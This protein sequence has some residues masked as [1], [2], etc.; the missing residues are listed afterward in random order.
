M[1]KRTECSAT[2]LT[3]A[4]GAHDVEDVVGWTEELLALDGRAPVGQ[5]PV[6]DSEQSDSVAEAGVTAEENC[7]GARPVPHPPADVYFPGRQVVCQTSASH[8]R[9]VLEHLC[10]A[11]RFV[12]RKRFPEVPLEVE[13]DVIDPRS[14]RSNRNEF[15]SEFREELPPSF[16]PRLDDPRPHELLEVAYVQGRFKDEDALGQ[17]HSMQP[18]VL[19]T[20]QQPSDAPMFVETDADRVVKKHNERTDDEDDADRGTEENEADDDV[21]EGDQER[22]EERSI[23][24]MDQSQHRSAPQQGSIG[25][26]GGRRLIQGGGGEGMR[27]RAG[28]GGVQRMDLLSSEFDDRLSGG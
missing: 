26:G 3:G 5:L 23:Q 16:V 24:L 11:P 1:E 25:C 20:A 8:L 7:R 18:E 17:G 6:E 28:E 9:S 14:S 2:I 12:V 10:R 19:W 13:S 4:D 22:S 21:E 27:G 15:L